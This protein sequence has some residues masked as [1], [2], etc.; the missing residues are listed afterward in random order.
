MQTKWIG[1]VDR[2]V[3]TERTDDVS[4]TGLI[5]G[6]V[7]G[8][9]LMLIG[10]LGLWTHIDATPPSS[11]LQVLRRRRP[12]PRLVVAPIAALV[13][14]FVVAALPAVMRAPVRAALFASAI[15]IAI[16]WPALRGYGR[17]ARPTTTPCNR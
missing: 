5:I 3:S 15:V 4:R 6:L 8:V 11:Y 16:A 10:V 14:F 9:P 2:D 7:I 13:G 17:I 1:K 12:P